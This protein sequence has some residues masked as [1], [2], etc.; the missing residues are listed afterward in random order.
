MVDLQKH[1][2]SAFNIQ[3]SRITLSTVPWIE[4]PFLKQKIDF[5]IISLSDFYENYRID[6][7]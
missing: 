2:Q 5:C 3:K 4:F 1:K 6:L 7:I